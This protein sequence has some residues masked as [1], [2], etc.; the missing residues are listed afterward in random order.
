MSELNALHDLLES[1][2]DEVVRSG[3]RIVGRRN[4]DW[5]GIPAVPP[6]AVLYPRTTRE[7]SQALSIC[8]AHNQPVAVQGGLSGLAGGGCTQAGDIALSLERM[9]TIEDVD[10]IAATMTVQAGVTLQ[11]VQER[12]REAGMM[13]PLDLGAR[14]SCTIGGNL[15]SNAGGNRVIKYGM[16]RAQVLDLEAVLA[17]GR[18]VGGV[19][20]MVKNNA[21]FDLRNLLIGSE[22]TLGVITRAV[23]QL[24][25]QPGSVAT[26]WCG[27]AD[28]DNVTALLRLTRN[29]LATG[30]SAFEV[31]WPGYYEYVL[32]NVDGLR[33]PLSARH[34]CY[35]L[36][37]SVGGDP[38]R[39]QADFEKVLQDCLEAGIIEDAVVAASDSDAREFWNVRD[40]PAAFP[41]LMP[42]LIAFD[43]SFSI[44]DMGRVSQ[45]CVARL[46]ARW[47]G[48]TVLVYGHLGD[49]N[50]HVIV[51]IAGASDET[52]LQVEAMVYGLVEEYAGSVSAEHGIGLKKRGVLGH[53]RSRADLEAM[54]AIKLALDPRDILNRGKIFPDD[55]VLNQ[56]NE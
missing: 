19:R 38:A 24:Q 5:S 26:A 3:E 36:L 17:D 29:R 25:A 49:G 43:I 16:A 2:G 51:N 27:L 35:V 52:V 44:A 45:D 8:H 1:L 55:I 54:R 41:I 9:N 32:A 46:G 39:H 4:A 10:E 22:G 40:A 7:V 31:M 50:L 30:I 14:G 47:P 13:F 53:T 34:G 37:E 42:R 23:L 28:F 56:R 12:A 15:G 18:I 11:T 48:S 6:L 20:K 21:G 33:A